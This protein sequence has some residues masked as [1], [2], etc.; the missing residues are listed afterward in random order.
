M[1]GDMD[2]LVV[3]ERYLDRDHDLR[4]AA[5]YVRAAFESRLR[6]L[7]QK[8][9]VVIR[10]NPNPNDVKSDA[11]WKGLLWRHAERKKKEKKLILDETLVPRLSAVR[12]AVLN[13]LSH[14]GTPALTELTC[15]Q[16][17][18]PCGIFAMLSY[19]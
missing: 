15:A 9:G 19:Q 3:A 10:Y 4:A 16:L 18:P 6:G 1:K 11:L 14:T 2:D 17:L 13:R 7:C 8:T 12:S 5:V